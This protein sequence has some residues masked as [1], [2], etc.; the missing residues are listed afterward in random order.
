MDF[1]KN[2]ARCPKTIEI[3]KS[4]PRFYNHA[5]ISNMAPETHITKHHGPTNKKLRVHLPLVVPKTSSTT[6]PAQCR[7]RVGSDVRS[8]RQGRAMVFDDS[9][10]HEAWNDS[11]ESRVVLVFDVWHPDLSDKEIKFLTY[12]QNAKLRSER[13]IASL[14]EQRDDQDADN[15]YTIID[16]NRTCRPDAKALWSM[17]GLQSAPP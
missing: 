7:I 1:E 8:V 5:F 17:P 15:L 4:I 3:L 11:L 9:F 6:H 13:K 16:K 10:E 14:A 12:V 2:R